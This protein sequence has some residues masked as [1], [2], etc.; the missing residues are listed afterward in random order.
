MMN[1]CILTFAAMLLAS[2]S[3]PARAG[4]EERACLAAVAAMRERAAT[5]PTGDLSRRFAENDLDTALM[6]MEAGDVDE[7]PGRVERAL[8]TLTKHPYKLR[9]GEILNGYGPDTQ[10]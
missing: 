1:R 2:A 7:C 5:L 6:E 4:D 3:Y 9:P 8:H 10:G